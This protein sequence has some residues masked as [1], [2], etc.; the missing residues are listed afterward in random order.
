MPRKSNRVLGAGEEADSRS[1]R[2]HAGYNLSR[3]SKGPTRAAAF[4]CVLAT[5]LAFV[6]FSAVAVDQDSD[7]IYDGGGVLNGYGE[8]VGR[9]GYDQH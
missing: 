1:V 8:E 2:T 6:A 7:T 4:L 9:D 3:M 5:R